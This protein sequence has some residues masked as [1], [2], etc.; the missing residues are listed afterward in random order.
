MD[1]TQDFSMPPVVPPI[2][3]RVFATYSVTADLSEWVVIISR[4][5]SVLA[6]RRGRAPQLRAW[7]EAV[8][9]EAHDRER[10]AR[11]LECFACGGVAAPP[12]IDRQHRDAVPDLVPGADVCGASHD[13]CDRVCGLHDHGGNDAH[14]L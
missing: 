5:Q 10:H 4:G 6:T 3:K 12:R 7:V 2:P 8:Y 9:P 13:L 11:G 14:R 1:N